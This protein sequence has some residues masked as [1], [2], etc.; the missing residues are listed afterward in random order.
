MVWTKD[1]Q[2]ELPANVID[3]GN[4]TLRFTSASLEMSG[5]YSCT[6]KGLHPYLRAT[7]VVNVLHK[8]SVDYYITINPQTMS[9]EEG[10]VAQLECQVETPPGAEDPDIVWLWNGSRILPYGVF[11]NRRGSLKFRETKSM[12]SGI[13]TCTTNTE[14]DS[15]ADATV[16]IK[17]S[18]GRQY[19]NHLFYPDATSESSLSLY[20]DI[21]VCLKA[22]CQ[23][24][25]KIGIM[26]MFLHILY[27]VNGK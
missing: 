20:H 23:T 25:N 17:A 16:S 4:N 10:K 8:V 15:S 24:N 6:L 14:S 27:F 12:Q 19:A 26:E 22:P 9:L 2:T 21:L 7:A 11:D 18:K 5:E 1:G 3:K 13:Y